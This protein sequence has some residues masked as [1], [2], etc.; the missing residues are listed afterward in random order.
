MGSF[1]A[2]P[3]IGAILKAEDISR[4]DTVVQVVVGNSLTFPR[5]SKDL[6]VI[7]TE[8]TATASVML[9]LSNGESQ[10]FEKIDVPLSKRNYNLFESPF[11]NDLPDQGDTGS[12]AFVQDKC[13]HILSYLD[14]KERTDAHNAALSTGINDERV[15]TFPGVPVTNYTLMQPPQTSQIAVISEKNTKNFSLRVEKIRKLVEQGG[16]CA[17]HDNLTLSEISKKVPDVDLTELELK[18]DETLSKLVK[19]LNAN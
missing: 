13:S 9:R 3:S 1:I 2:L 16:A 8:V 4:V 18:L 12:K 7:T 10:I 11:Y 17:V 5:T 6:F 14:M 19:L 15:A